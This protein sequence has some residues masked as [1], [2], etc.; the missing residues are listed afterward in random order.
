MQSEIPILVFKNCVYLTSSIKHFLPF[1]LFNTLKLN[2]VFAISQFDNVTFPLQAFADLHGCLDLLS[3]TN[4]YIESHFSEVLDCDEFYGLTPDQVQFQSNLRYALFLY[5]N[6]LIPFVKKAKNDNFLAKI[7]F[8]SA[9][10]VFKAKIDGTL[11]GQLVFSIISSYD[12]L[13][14]L[15]HC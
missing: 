14:K 1:R 6:S 2:F 10:L 12:V 11:S 3:A 5:A 15:K 8:R 7:D 9:N 13:T 4:T